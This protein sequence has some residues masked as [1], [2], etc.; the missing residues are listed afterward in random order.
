MKQIGQCATQL[1]SESGLQDPDFVYGAQI[2][3]G[4]HLDTVSQ[5]D[6]V[7]IWGMDTFGLP[8]SRYVTEINV[9]D[10]TWWFRSEHDRLLFVLRNGQAR[11]TQLE[12]TA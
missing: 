10:M 3:W 5:W 8:G 7:A 4:P 2:T 6:Q 9:N 1:F 12:S 11:C